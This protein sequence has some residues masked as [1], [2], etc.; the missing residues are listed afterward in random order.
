MTVV[1]GFVLAYAVVALEIFLYIGWSAKTP[2]VYETTSELAKNHRIVSGDLRERAGS[3]RNWDP[4]ARTVREFDGRYVAVPRLPPATPVK[5]T[6]LA[7]TPQ[8]TPPDKDHTLLWL[9]ASAMQP[10]EFSDLEPNTV[11]DICG[12][13]VPKKPCIQRAPVAARWCDATSPPAC[14]LGVWI[15]AVD[16]INL[17]KV[18]DRPSTATSKPALRIVNLQ[19][20]ERRK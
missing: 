18:L 6:D 15:A 17:L 5:Q 2:I 10:P 4:L 16:R 13:D 12:L 3:Y 1:Q 20:T 9:P 7:R 8:L 19:R 11:V 14:F